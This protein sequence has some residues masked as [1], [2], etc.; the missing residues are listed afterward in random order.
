MQCT[1]LPGLSIIIYKRKKWELIIKNWI[2]SIGKSNNKLTDQFIRNV[3]VT[4]C[5]LVLL[6]LCLFLLHEHFCY[7]LTESIEKG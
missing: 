5:F 3:S 2:S 1:F 6:L 7:A 4:P